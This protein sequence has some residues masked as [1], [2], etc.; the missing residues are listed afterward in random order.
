VADRIDARQI[1]ENLPSADAQ[2]L[3]RHSEGWTSQEIAE[4]LHLTAGNVRLRISR[5][6]GRVRGTFQN[7]NLQANHD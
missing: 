6:L 3:T 5:L 7:T 4:E 1:L 2:L